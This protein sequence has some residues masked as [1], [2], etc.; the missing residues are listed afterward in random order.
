MAWEEKLKVLEAR[1][2]HLSGIFAKHLEFKATPTPQSVL[3]MYLPRLGILVIGFYIIKMI[4]V[5]YRYNIHSAD[6]QDSIADEAE[7]LYAMFGDMK[8]LENPADKPNKVDAIFGSYM[9]RL[10]VPRPAQDPLPKLSVGSIF[11][12]TKPSADKKESDG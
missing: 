9:A 5:I 1:K 3:M 2:D 4:T 7:L 8:S 6:S 12:A 11:K 10:H